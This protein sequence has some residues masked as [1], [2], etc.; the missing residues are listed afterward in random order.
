M[1]TEQDLLSRSDSKCEL[2]SS[3]ENLGVYEIPPDSDGSADQCI[4][5]CSTCQNQI[6]NHIVHAITLPTQR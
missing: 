5:L 2:C 3:T 6:D 4:L 1:S